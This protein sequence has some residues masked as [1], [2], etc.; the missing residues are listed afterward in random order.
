MV[1]RVYI[2]NSVI[3]GFFDDEFAFPT[4]RLFREITG[5][6]YSAVISS[7]TI[8]EINGAPDPVMTFFR[9]V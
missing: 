7:I 1:K 3:G 5:G 6:L 2:D 8:E 4:K 9:K